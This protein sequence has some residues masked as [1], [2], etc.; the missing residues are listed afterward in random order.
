MDYFKLLFFIAF[1]FFGIFGQQRFQRHFI[2]GDAQIGFMEKLNDSY[3]DDI[4]DELAADQSDRTPN[5]IQ[6]DNDVQLIGYRGEVPIE[7]NNNGELKFEF[8]P[9]D[10]MGK[11]VVV[12][13]DAK[14]IVS[15][16]KKDCGPNRCEFQAGVS[17]LGTKSFLWF[18][19]NVYATRV[20]PNKCETAV[21]KSP[22]ATTSFVT[23]DSIDSCEPLKRDV[24][25]VNILVKDVP[26]GCIL[27]VRNAKIWYPTTPSPTT[28]PS[29]I[30]TTEDSSKAETTIWIVLGVLLF[31][32]VIGIFGFGIYCC[33]FKKDKK[34]VGIFD[35][36]PKEIVL[37]EN[38]KIPETQKIN[39]A[40]DIVKTEEAKKEKK[41]TVK[42]KP[43]KQ[44][45]EEVVKPKVTKAAPLPEKK[46][47]AAF[48]EPTLD[49]PSTVQPPKEK[50][51]DHFPSV[52]VLKELVHPTPKTY[53]KRI[54]PKPGQHHSNKTDSLSGRHEVSMIGLVESPSESLKH[55]CIVTGSSD[56]VDAKLESFYQPGI[57]RV[58]LRIEIAIFCCT[59]SAMFKQIEK[60]IDMAEE[61]LAERDVT[62]DEEGNIIQMTAKAEE[63]LEKKSTPEYI[64]S[65]AF[66]QIYSALI[67][68]HVGILD[69]L[70][71][72]LLFV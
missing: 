45:K 58:L 39:V 13:Y 6:F 64:R 21:M 2:T 11:T 34:S 17:Q 15:S 26:P 68:K 66:G 71:I 22:E 10:C 52:K 12:C 72:P 67:D 28:Q 40:S 63:Y 24:N 8:C 49:E 69:T 32:I 62:F 37:E 25:V 31:F 38:K 30:A 55:H 54:K 61:A 42:D 41:E 4:R 47:A 51:E 9:D 70:S 23:P 33:C 5:G 36:K 29:E 27:K 53:A 20:I 59:I 56:F 19:S 44:K 7:L 48:V 18:M 16:L 1:L 46:K 65:Y 35:E 60:M 57:V 3:D 14:N 50:V 43:P